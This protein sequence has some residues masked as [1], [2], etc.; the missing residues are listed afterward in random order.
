[1]AIEKLKAK[2]DM[3]KLKSVSPLRRLWTNTLPSTMRLYE[4]M[5]LNVGTGTRNIRYPVPLDVD[6]EA[7]KNRRLL[8][9]TVCCDLAHLPFRH[10]IF[11]KIYCFHVLE[12]LPNPIEGLRE[13]I[14]VCSGVLELE[15][16]HRF[17]YLAKRP[18]HQASFRVCWFNKALKQFSYCLKTTWGFPRD[19]NIHVWIF[20]RLRRTIEC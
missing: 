15:V 7:D 1:M 5:I 8:G 20:T 6:V 4:S 3:Q 13:L 16:P 10:G 12:H 17:S 2:M 19:I 18:D 9:V 11:E 14:R